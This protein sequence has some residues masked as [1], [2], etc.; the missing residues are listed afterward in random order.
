MSGEKGGSSL[1]WVVERECAEMQIRVALSH[2]NRGNEVVLMTGRALPE[3][4]IEDLAQ[5]GVQVVNTK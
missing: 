4:R 3:D 1:Y 2:R 5:A